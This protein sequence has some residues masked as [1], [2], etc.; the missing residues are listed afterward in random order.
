MHNRAHV[1]GAL[2]VGDTTAN[3]FGFVPARLPTL[4]DA[5]PALAITVSLGKINALFLSATGAVPTVTGIMP[6]AVPVGTATVVTVSGSNFR[7]GVTA[8]IG[9][10]CSGTF[11]VSASS[12]RC[13]VSS[14]LT[15]GSYDVVVLNSDGLSGLASR[16]FW[17][18]GRERKG[19]GHPLNGRC[20][21]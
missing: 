7:S 15:Y 11:D 17:T 2:G 13:I 18:Q 21:G 1:Q 3:Y 8:T 10:L 9:E 16:A 12:F 4:D 14:A 6:S 5:T 20:A 19:V